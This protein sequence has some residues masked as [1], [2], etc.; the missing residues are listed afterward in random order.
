MKTGK[1]ILI[2]AALLFTTAAVHAQSM[3]NMI[4]IGALAG[5]SVPSNNSAAAA[6]LDVAY[7]N[8][9][10][11]HFGLGVATGYQH[12]FGKEND[13]NGAKLDNNSFGVVPVAALVRYYPKAEGIYIGTDLG[14]GVITGDKRVEPNYSVAR[15]DGGFYL[16]PEVGYHNRNWNIFAHYSKVFTGDKGTINVGNASQKYNTGIIG[17][18]LAYNIGLGTG[19]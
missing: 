18:G 14:Y 2:G 1:A 17:V 6:G 10:T 3:K 5:A 7:Q 12:H 11:P 9:V 4:K 15:P 13:V 8:L 19:R 16:K